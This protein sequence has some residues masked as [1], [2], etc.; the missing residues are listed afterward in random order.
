MQ[1]ASMKLHLAAVTALQILPDN[2]RFMSASLDST[3]FLSS[4]IPDEK[5]VAFSG[6]S[7]PIHGGCLTKDQVSHQ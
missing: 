5:R 7:G 1:L 2:S 4:T 6:A 3:L